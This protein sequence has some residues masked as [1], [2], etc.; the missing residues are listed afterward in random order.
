MKEKI[1]LNDDINYNKWELEGI[2]NEMFLTNRKRFIENLKR[3]IVDLNYDSVIVLKSGNITYRYDTDVPYYYFLQETNFFYLTGVREPG[4]YAILD[5]LN[6]KLTLFYNEP[7][8][9]DQIWRK[10][11]TSDEISKKYGLEV[12]PLEKMNYWFECRS[13]NTIYIPEGLYER[14]GHPII[15]AELDFEKSREYLNKRIEHSSKI[16]EVLRYSRSIKSEAEK[17]LLKLI[18][19][20]T[21]EAHLEMM[22]NVKPE[23][24]ERDRK[25]FL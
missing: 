13:M 18:G 17:G 22:K 4:L 24:Y 2:P 8:S 12:Y 11:L 25:Y 10:N 1:N 19:D 9:E 5:L 6:S 20:K 16:Y 7:S 3:V 21:N 15:M 23:M 14:E